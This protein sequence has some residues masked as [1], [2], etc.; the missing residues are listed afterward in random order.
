MDLVQRHDIDS[1]ESVLY[2]LS[3]QK[4]LRRKVKIEPLS[5]SSLNALDAS[6]ESDSVQKVPSLDDLY[7][8]AS[9]GGK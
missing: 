9:L 5:P 3:E 2:D 1:E 4:P 7:D 6:S 8:E